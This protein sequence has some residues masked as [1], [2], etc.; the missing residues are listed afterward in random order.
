MDRLTEVLDHIAAVWDRQNALNYV[1]DN[2]HGYQ[3]L[4]MA[5]YAFARDPG[6]EEYFREFSNS[7]VRL[8]EENPWHGQ[9]LFNT[10][11]LITHSL[12]FEML[13]RWQAVAVRCRGTAGQYTAYR[14]HVRFFRLNASMA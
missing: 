7:F 3:T 2:P 1:R 9:D 14:D 4:R 12:E 13:P 11:N 10:L 5:T 8:L 6:N